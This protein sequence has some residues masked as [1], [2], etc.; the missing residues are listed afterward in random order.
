MAR[1]LPGAGSVRVALHRMRGVKMG[2][3]V[4]IGY[5]TI[6]E[7]SYP[8]LVSIG[9]DVE[10]S[11]R[12]LIMAHWRE[13]SAR[14]KGKSRDP[15]SVRIEDKVMIGPGA[16]ILQNVTIGEGSVVSAGSVVTK[17]IPPMTMVQGNPAKAIATC[18]VP[19]TGGVPFREFL[20]KLKPIKT[21]PAESVD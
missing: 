13:M 6:I 7:T 9:N 15:V 5:D 12:V 14:E 20:F 17:S 19:L 4:W 16:I 1:I 3:N 2:K 21:S 8:Y 11:A 10:I 18:G